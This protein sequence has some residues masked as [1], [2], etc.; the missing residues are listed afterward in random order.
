MECC[1][2]CKQIFIKKTSR[3]IYCKKECSVKYHRKNGKKF[4]FTCQICNVEFTTKNKV[5]IFCSLKCSS[6]RMKKDGSDY[7]YF[8]KY[9]DMAKKNADKRN[10]NKTLLKNSIRQCLYC[11]KGYTPKKNIQ[12]YCSRICSSI[13]LS[14]KIKTG[15]IKTNSNNRGKGEIYLS[16][17]CIN[18]FG[19]DDILCNEKIFKD[20][21]GGLWDADIVIKSLK[22]A[23]LYDGIFHHKQ[24][25]KNHKLKQIQSRDKIKRTIIIENGY[26]FYTIN[27]LDKF[28]KNFV[29]DQFN[30]FIHRLN[31]KETL[32]NITFKNT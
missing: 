31:F 22:T 30:L 1:K 2:E 19:N 27:D 24:V 32:N 21:N 29:E 20:K 8:T 28:N 17:L 13:D 14:F 10:L 6:S 23:I 18:Y 25:K 7:E 3:Q 9:S 12:K 5:Q 15:I 26:K 11:N 4:T 16:E